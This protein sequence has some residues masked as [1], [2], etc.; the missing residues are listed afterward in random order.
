MYD[1]DWLPRLTALAGDTRS[2]PRWRVPSNVWGL[3]ITSLLTDASSEMVVSVLPAY[4]VLSAGLTPMALGVATGLHAAGPILATWIGGVVAD[5]SGRRKVTAVSGYAL[6]AACRLGWWALMPGR[7]VS[8][9]ALFI[10]GDRI[11]KA[12]RTAPRDAMISL[13]AHSDQMATA[14]GVHRALDAAGAAAGPLIAW[15]VLWQLPRRY[16]V[17]FFASF[18]LALLG[19][20]AL[21]LLVRDA[22]SP[23]ATNARAGRPTVTEAV[24]VFDDPRFGRVVLLAVAFSFV[25]IGDAFLYLLLLQRTQAGAQ[26]IPLFYTGTAVSFLILAV[27]LGYVA[28][29]VGRRR[30]FI[31]GHVALLMTYGMVSSGVVPWPWAAGGS[32]LLLGMYYAASDGVLAGLAGAVLPSATRATG[33]A[34]IATGVGLGRLGSALMFGFLSTRYGAPVAVTVFAVPLTI[35]IAGFARDGR[36]PTH[37]DGP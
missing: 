36:E 28:D 14:F 30:V 33:L 5:R 25:S 11:G 26:W 15:V 35:A 32:V 2:V 1:A 18:V 21:T 10:L 4:L 6:S 23:E 34:W 37:G 3:G 13:S 12:I 17:V 16:D 7:V 8:L 20:A 27:P 19:L 29:R 31:L 24:A 9:L 22:P